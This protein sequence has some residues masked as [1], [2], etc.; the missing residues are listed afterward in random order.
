MTHPLARPTRRSVLA[1]LAAVAAG[2]AH[3]QAEAGRTL[4]AAPAP[5]RLRPD[6]GAEAELWSFDGD[7]AGPVL[8]VRQGEEF[9]LRLVNR[10]PKP[11]SLHWHGVRGP[12]AMDGAGGLTQEPVAPGGSFAYAFTPPEAGTFLIRPCLLGGS[13]EP[14]ERGLSG[15]LIVEEAAPPAV[16]REVVALVDDWLLAADGALA[17]FGPTEGN[18][19]RLGN[20]LTV[21]GRPVPEAIRAA[22]GERVRLRVA[23]ACNA[24]ETRLRFDGLRPYVAAIDG[25]PTDTFEPLRASVPFPPGT[26]Y[27]FLLDLPAEAGATGSVMA[28]IGEGVPLIAFA[29]EGD[30]RPARPA[31]APLPPNRTLPAAIRLQNALR[32]DVVLRAGPTPAPW[33]VNGAA[34]RPGAPLLRAKRGQPVVLA[35]KNETPVMQPFHLHGHVFRLLHPFDDGWEPYFLDTVQVPES[36]TVRIAFNADNPGRWLLASTVLERFDAGLW[37]WI[38]VG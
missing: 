22:P 18:L 30:P 6:S 20:W 5:R 9:R 13:A 31:I 16:D 15:L 28:T 11:L 26:R 12:N 1:G 32:K 10:T 21:N 2:P 25:Q 35:L 36:R 17:P 33:L 29:V 7:A 37:T 4:T 14:A 38:E 8:R 19:G 27:D 34:G 3:P 24:R 23:N